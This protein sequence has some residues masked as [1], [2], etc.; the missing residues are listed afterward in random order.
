MA[1]SSSI[2]KT[3]P[4]RVKN[5][6]SFLREYTASSR[7]A[8]YVIAV[9]VSFVAIAIRLFLDPMLDPGRA[10]FL[11]PLIAVTFTA[12][13]GGLKP[14]LL[15]EVICG[16]GITYLILPPHFVLYPK[17]PEIEANIL[18][19]FVGGAIFAVIGSLVY[20][21]RRAKDAVSEQ[22]EHMFD[23][24]VTG[25]TR[26]SRDLRYLAVNQAYAQM[27]GLPEDEI[28][29]QKLEDV[30]G[31]EAF[32]IIKPYIDHVL[33]GRIVEYQT[34]LPIRNS[35][36]RTL[37]VQYAP[38]RNTKGDI[39]GWVASVVN[40]TDQKAF[41]IVQARLGAIID[42]SHDA[43]VSKN[44]DTTITSWN[45]AAERLFGYQADEAI[46]KSI[47]M[48]IP[49]ERQD[50][51]TQILDKIRHGISV[52]NYETVRLRKDGTPVD[53]SLTVSPIRAEDG[54]IVGASKIAHDITARKRSAKALAESEAETR[55]LQKLGSELVTEDDEQAIYD[56]IIAAAV[57]LMDAQFA[58]IQLY[59]SQNGNTPELE[60]LA[61]RGFSKPSAKLWKTVNFDSPSSCG[62]ALRRLQRVEIPDIEDEPDLAGTVHLDMYRE[63][64]IRAMQSTP[65]VSR[66]GNLVGM[67][68]TH[69]DRPH[70]AEDR[71]LRAFDLLARQATEILERRENAKSTRESEARKAAI[72]ASAI[73]CLITM[74]HEGRIVD[75]NR[76]AEQT[77]GWSRDEVVG[78]PVADTIIPERLR[79][80]HV[81]GLRR[82]LHTGEATVLG[83]RLE[84]PAL[85]SDGS[86]FSAELSI[87]SVESAD[88]PPFFTAFIRDITE[89]K[90]AE[91]RIAD[92]LRAMTRLRDLGALSARAD[93]DVDLCLEAILDAAIDFT[94][95][96]KGNI[97][98]FRPDGEVL[99]IVRYSGF[100]VDFLNFFAA[101]DASE[102]AA[103]SAALHGLRR[104]VVED[105][106]KSK[107]F[108]G[109]PS[110]QILLDEGIRAVQSTPLVSGT[111][112]A[113]GMI[114]TH[115]SEPNRP[116]DR[117]LGLIDLLARQTADM[118]ERRGA[119]DQLENLVYERT[120]ELNAANAALIAEMESRL[121]GKADRSSKSSRPETTS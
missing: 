24:S 121:T 97:Q 93:C 72:L 28:V 17:G 105:I 53:V 67:I 86:E 70:Q 26:C 58:S 75:F 47:R 92:D 1:K 23:N 56:K 61:F 29:G 104:V 34:Q 2:S 94:R 33:D 83:E 95:A 100:G 98:L 81:E 18:T 43:I 10:A 50:E 120:R 59:H 99:E 68:S 78:K 60:L 13:F 119:H 25:L 22:L 64:G 9:A 41:E 77:F 101:V 62:T 40:L 52:D 103:C 11:V 48:L 106:T 76:A 30:L 74:D 114:S 112:R 49:D 79:K 116:S 85:R 12:I 44:L 109:Q 108:I 20:R 54:T 57:T 46:G 91:K 66:S 21:A 4:E 27:V 111:G 84:M 80:A 107:I 51:E 65:L 55:L 5:V 73:D 16:V 115:F 38:D 89:R 82:Y 32:D 88:G 6:S 69:W 3:L 110:L 14:A 42:S 63:A 71:Q 118:I 7:A 8:T 45:A 102:A 35:G 90:L 19:Y 117:E 15:T 36:T 87:T 37:N 31:K 96:A 39:V 113:L